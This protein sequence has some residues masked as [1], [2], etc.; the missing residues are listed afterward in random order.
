MNTGVNMNTSVPTIA[1]YSNDHDFIVM[2]HNCDFAPVVSTGKKTVHS[3][4]TMCSNVDGLADHDIVIYDLDMANENILQAREDILHLKLN[5]GSRPLV[6]VGQKEFMQTVVSSENIAQGVDCMITKPVLP[7]DLKIVIDA[8]L[9]DKP[10]ALS[11]PQAKNSVLGLRSSFM[12]VLGGAA[13]VT[14]DQRV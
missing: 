4:R 11:K 13:R 8:T 5:A 14:S 9:A 2:I 6:L 7:S 3:F 12:S 1:A 10:K